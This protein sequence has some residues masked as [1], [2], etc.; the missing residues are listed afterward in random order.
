MLALLVLDESTYE[1]VNITIINYFWN[2]TIHYAS[3]PIQ[4]TIQYTF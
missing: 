2:A 4:S 3:K 1:K